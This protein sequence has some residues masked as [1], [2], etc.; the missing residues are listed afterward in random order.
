MK[1]SADSPAC[2]SSLVQLDVQDLD[3][4]ELGLGGLL[5]LATV[6]TGLQHIWQ[7][8][9]PADLVART[10]Q[11]MIIRLADPD[12]TALAEASVEF[13]D[14]R[15]TQLLS[16]RPLAAAEH[17]PARS[18]RVSSPVDDSPVV[19]F[20]RPPSPVELCQVQSQLSDL[21]RW[22]FLLLSRSSLAYRADYLE[23]LKQFTAAARLVGADSVAHLVIPDAIDQKSVLSRLTTGKL[24]N[25]CKN[26][27]TALRE[28]GMVLMFSGLSGSGK[29]TLARA[30]QEHIH[31]HSERRAV[32]LDGDDV[33]R[34]VSKGL[35]FSREDRETNVE[36]I[37]WIA[38]RISESGGIALCAP[39]APFAG[40]RA[41]VKDLAQAVG[42]YV[43]I[44]VSTPLEVCEERDRKGLY[45][46]ARAG[47]IPDFTGISSPYEIPADAD[48]RVDLSVLSIDEATALVIDKIQLDSPTSSRIR[49]AKTTESNQ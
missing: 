32:L 14:S 4:V 10:R 5:D 45:A 6:A 11:T 23:D 15:A 38:S 18:L 25:A 35:G 8:A 36:R 42:S 33:R 40:T 37:G 41:T 49:T 22:K 17:G 3:I 19:V 29:S 9:I 44:H 21:E 20:D 2:S 27:R 24:W 39:I 43:L 1:H 7:Q 31:T 47:L 13:G 12:G 30:V 28:P 26:T 34:F 48:L 16:L 46:K